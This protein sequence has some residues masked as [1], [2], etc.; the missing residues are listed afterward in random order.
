M[1]NNKLSRKAG[2]LGRT[3]L[4]LPD[5]I[6]SANQVIAKTVAEVLDKHYPEHLWA[7][8]ADVETGMC[9]IR[10][11][12]LDGEFGYS[13]RLDDLIN[14]SKLKIVVIGGGELLERFNLSRGKLKQHELTDLKQDS[15]GRTL[16]Q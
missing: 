6:N 11:L 14:D 3:T 2:K 7:V 5:K 13:I 9:N 10:N 4:H 12:N 1:S 16:H 15:V 8:D